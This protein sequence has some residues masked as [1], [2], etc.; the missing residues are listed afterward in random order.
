MSVVAMPI[1]IADSAPVST[2][3]KAETT[4]AEDSVF[5]SLVAA[6]LGATAAAQPQGQAITGAQAQA[7]TPDTAD[8]A[9]GEAAKDASAGE[10]SPLETAAQAAA[11]PVVAAPANNPAMAAFLQMN[12]AAQT[13]TAVPQP[14][15]DSGSQAAQ[16]PAAAGAPTDPQDGADL[17]AQAPQADAP[18]E[19]AELQKTA[20]PAEPDAKQKSGGADTLSAEISGAQAR[21]AKP[22][23]PNA[24]QAQAATPSAAQATSPAMA[25]TNPQ[26][27]APQ[28]I[29]QA[30]N[31]SPAFSMQASVKTQGDAAVSPSD[32]DTL[33]LRIAAR[34]AQGDSRFDIRLDPPELGRIDVQLH[35]DAKG[36]AHAALSADKPQ[37]LE[38]LQ[39]DSAALERAM[40]EAGVSL[41]GN[42]S[43]SLK[44][45]GKQADG[46]DPRGPNRKAGLTVDGVEGAA[47]LSAAQI[48][49]LNLNAGSIRLDIRV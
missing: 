38:L 7:A 16:A 9:E 1:A 25:A 40:K 22:Q 28:P 49:N 13:Q 11:A 20:K 31:T 29:M 39:R 4:S 48:Q 19:N 43:F 36:Q 12:A 37:T 42:L 10:A 24:A 15:S 14:A 47:A 32:Y 5:A 35:V 26:A 6:M 41:G 8:G 34:S 33:A 27:V 3:P 30:Q 45:E 17:K 21:E 23:T 44:G 2:G 18:A 46:R